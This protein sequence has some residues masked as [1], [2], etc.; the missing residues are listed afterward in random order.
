MSN[1][2]GQVLAFPLFLSRSGCRRWYVDDD[3]CLD[4]EQRFGRM[5]GEFSDTH[6]LPPETIFD[7]LHAGSSELSDAWHRTPTVALH[8]GSG[9]GLTAEAHTRSERQTG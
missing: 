5:S 4:H 1:A 3:L 2:D 8:P 7:L 9:L 6:R